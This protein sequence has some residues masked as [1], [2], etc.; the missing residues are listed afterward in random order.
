M[1]IERVLSC[2]MSVLGSLLGLF[3]SIWKF[4]REIVTL[5]PLI[6]WTLFEKLN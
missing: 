1:A 3:S 5:A 6:I 2:S 4:T